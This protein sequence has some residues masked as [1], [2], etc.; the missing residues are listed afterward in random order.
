MRRSIVF[1]F[2]ATGLCIAAG[3]LVAGCASSSGPSQGARSG[4]KKTLV[5]VT[6]DDEAIDAR[7]AMGAIEPVWWTGD[8]Y[9]DEKTYNESLSEFT[10][11]QRHV[12]AV[13]WHMSEVDNGGHEQFYSNGTGIVWRDA[14]AGYRA[15][16][17]DEAAAILEE[18]ASRMGGDPSM[19]RQTRQLQLTNLRPDFNDLD[20]RYYACQ[21]EI[22]FGAAM[23]DYVRAHREAFYFD[24]DVE[25]LVWSSD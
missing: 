10:A 25:E 16:G 23:L 20:D 21:E 4:Y 22:D 18:S 12:L 24:G 15:M 2:G 9:H 3:V 5:H 13:I 11:E 7:D 6:I 14:L 8:I 1:T 17:L 19:D